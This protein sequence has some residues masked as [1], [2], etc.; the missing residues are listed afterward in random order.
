MKVS[1][2]IPVYYNE[3]NLIPLY[4]D[5][6]EKFID[7]IDYDYEIVMVNDGSKDKSYEVMCELAKKDQNIKAV[8]LSRNFGSHAACL[9]GLAHATGDCAVIKAADLQE[10]TELILDMVES[11]KQGNNVVLACREGREESKSQV[12]FANLYYWLVRKT[13]LPTMPK[14]GFDI[15]LLDR[16]AIDVINGLDEKNSAITGQILWSGFRTGIVY[17]TRK[18]REIGESKWTLKKKI[19]LVSDTLFSF[20]TL[21]IR[22]LEIV[23][24]LSFVIG[25][26]WALVVLIAKLSGGIS[27]SGFT[28]LF[29]FNLLSFGIT[30]SSMGILGEYLWRSFDA[31]R[32]RPP[33]IVEDRYEEK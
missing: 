4:S 18:A 6:R 14:N 15:Y 3:D 24:V 25:I 5:L 32:N 20:S 1:I 7:K 29:I 8:S 19:R 33:Y 10:P 23:G 26:I 31:S 22:M 2:V 12:G 13:S 11:W 27:V 28:T 21:P 30:M 9:C 17:Y 16:K